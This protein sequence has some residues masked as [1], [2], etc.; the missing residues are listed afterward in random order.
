[1]MC[2]FLQKKEGQEGTN[3]P[4]PKAGA[5]GGGLLPPPPGGV[6]LAPPPA[7][8]AASKIGSSGNMDILGDLSNAPANPESQPAATGGGESWGDFASA[9]AKP[10]PAR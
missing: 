9:P 7:P 4:K 2:I 8:A 6:K 10:Q 3:R 1:M 5:A